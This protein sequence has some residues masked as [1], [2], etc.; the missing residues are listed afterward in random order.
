MM[1]GFFW[2]FFTLSL[3]S[4]VLVDIHITIAKEIPEIGRNYTK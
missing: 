3:I 4:H 2:D 1:L